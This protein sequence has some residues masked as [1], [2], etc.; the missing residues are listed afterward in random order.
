[1]VCNKHARGAYALVMLYTGVRRGECL[2]LT[3]ED[4]NIEARKLNVN[5][6]VEYNNSNQGKITGTKASKLRKNATGRDT[7]ARTVPIPDILI[8]TLTALCDGKE[9]EDLLFHKKD[10][11]L[12]SQIAARR[13][14]S[15]LKRW[16]HIAAGAKLYRNAVL[17]ET[18]PFDPDITQ[19]YLRH[20]YATD[21]PP[22]PLA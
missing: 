7:G 10:G 19:H 11:C 4:V 3:A 5:K 17:V 12:A 14:W 9:A 18:S 6:S 2:A 20:T 1:M 21:L 22:R 15:S 13:W 8:S 16:C